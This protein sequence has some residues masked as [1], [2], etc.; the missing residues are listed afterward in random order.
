MLADIHLCWTP[1]TWAA[2]RHGHNKV[3][4][5]EC[6]AQVW[7]CCRGRSSV[8]QCQTWSRHLHSCQEHNDDEKQQ[9][10][11]VCCLSKHLSVVS[12]HLPYSGYSLSSCWWDWHRNM[13]GMHVELLFLF[14]AW[15]CS[16]EKSSKLMELCFHRS[17]PNLHLHCSRLDISILNIIKNQIVE[18]ATVEMKI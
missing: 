14:L 18:F 2:S 12:I 5:V 6:L 8:L 10:L 16:H 17:S 4:I 3:C 11:I 9:T 1:A 13:C 15:Q 7:H